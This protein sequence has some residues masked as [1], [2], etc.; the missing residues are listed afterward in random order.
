MAYVG[1]EGSDAV[2]LHA[3]H[4]V[5]VQALALMDPSGRLATMWRT[6]VTDVSPLNWGLFGVLGLAAE[7][8]I[9]VALLVSHYA[10]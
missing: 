6:Q 9:V 4:G 1:H 5:R 7:F 10:L 2:H 3:G 8:W